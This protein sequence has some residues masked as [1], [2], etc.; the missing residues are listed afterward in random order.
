MI[1]RITIPNH[2]SAKFQYSSSQFVFMCE[3]EMKYQ[4]AAHMAVKEKVEQLSLTSPS[5]PMYTSLINS[6]YS[7]FIQV[8][9]LVYI[10]LT[11]FRPFWSSNKKIIILLQ[12]TSMLTLNNIKSECSIFKMKYQ[13]VFHDVVFVLLQKCIFDEQNRIY[14]STKMS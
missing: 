14:Y 5:I 2:R 4:Q 10:T 7:I 13:H 8:Q 9:G 3:N 6:W 1:N 11:Y 12:H